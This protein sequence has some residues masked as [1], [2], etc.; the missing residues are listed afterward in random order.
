MKAMFFKGRDETLWSGLLYYNITL[1]CCLASEFIRNDG[2]IL[3]VADE[4]G[5]ATIILHYFTHP[6]LPC[7]YILMEK[8]LS[9]KKECLNLGLEN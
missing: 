8:I 3:P 6:L 1:P 7:S 4:M 5:S 9:T 2:R